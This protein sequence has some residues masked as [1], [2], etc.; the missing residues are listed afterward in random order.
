[1]RKST[2][3]LRRAIAV[4]AAAAVMMVCI[5]V[6]LSGSHTPNSLERVLATGELK[7]V[8]R[9]GP[10]TYFEGPHGL[11]GYDYSLAKGFADYLGV[12]LVIAEEE[13]LGS[14]FDKVRAGQADMAA[15]G[16]TIT[17]ERQLRVD[18][19]LPYLEVQELVLYRSGAGRPKTIEDL[20]GKDI[21]VLANSAHAERLRQ[22]AIT[23]PDL[24]W[25]EQSN[26]EMSDLMDMLHRGETDIVV[27]DSNSFEINRSLYPMARKAFA[28]SEQSSHLAWAF[29]NSS[30]KS[31][32]DSANRY[33]QE[34]SNNGQLAELQ[35]RFYNQKNKLDRASALTFSQRL[36][37]RLPR[38]QEHLQA[39]GEK[40]ELDWRLLAAI[41]YQ[42]SHWNPKAQSYTGVRG[43][44]MLT[45]ATAK[46]MGVEDRA[47]PVQS[48]HGGAR[49]FRSVLD[50]MPERIKGNDRVWMA[51]A[52][53]NIGM[54]HLEDAR[55]LTERAGRNPNKWIDVREFLPLL[56][57]RQHYS[58]VKHGYARGWEPVEYVRSIRSFRTTIALH[59][60][61]QQRR[62]ASS[63]GIPSAQTEESIGL[64]GFFSLL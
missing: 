15:A 38:W 24:R 35:T 50:R 31:L 57:K 17:P 61:A 26:L 55:V 12:D 60:Q 29:N 40:F 63:Q 27:I 54:G 4:R 19:S 32:L 8:S 52:A 53:Y 62:L 46:D 64:F 6:A 44:M 21:T 18:F 33:L 10:T 16:L 58:K 41:S 49:Y 43:L 22:L 59:E 47:D 14:L 23:H 37:S 56:S 39:A 36:D 2:S 51:L 42:E 25:Q 1:M 30:D 9:N 28:L 13:N 20:Y 48:I 11:D 34:V 7:I 3:S 5:A 45:K